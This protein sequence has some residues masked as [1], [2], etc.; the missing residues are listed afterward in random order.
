MPASSLARLFF[1]S[2]VSLMVATVKLHG[3]RIWNQ[4]SANVWIAFAIFWQVLFTFSRLDSDF[5]VSPKE[6]YARVL[7]WRTNGFFGVAKTKC[8]WFRQR[9]TS[10][11][12]P[13]TTE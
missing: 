6:F 2:S 7:L 1:N 12:I 5:I 11:S 10:R 3:L 13:G 4:N 9:C 8:R